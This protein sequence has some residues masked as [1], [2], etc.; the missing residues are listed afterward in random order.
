M[1]RDRFADAPVSLIKDGTVDLAII[2]G[3]THTSGAFRP[4]S[5]VGMADM[6]APL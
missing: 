6:P 3:Y 2:K 5:V 4:G 1:T